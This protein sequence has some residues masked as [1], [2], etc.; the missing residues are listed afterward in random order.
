[1]R[2]PRKAPA[3]NTTLATADRKP[4]RKPVIRQPMHKR[5][6]ADYRSKRFPSVNRHS[7]AAT[8]GVRS[9]RCLAT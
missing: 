4:A 9:P 2:T 3:R 6:E 5:H 8:Y 1:M 7:L